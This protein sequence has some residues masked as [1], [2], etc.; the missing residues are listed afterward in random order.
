VAIVSIAALAYAD[1]L[2]SFVSPMMGHLLEGTPTIVMRNGEFD[3]D[4][5]RKE[6]MNDEDVLGHLREL[7]IHDVREVR[8]AIVENDGTVSVL[9]QSWAE[10]AQKADVL[11][12]EHDRRARAIG[13]SDTTPKDKRTDSMKALGQK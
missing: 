12:D 6:R 13:D 10:P 3:H 7:G 9:K 11:K 2:L 8:L 5:Q 4:G 1:S